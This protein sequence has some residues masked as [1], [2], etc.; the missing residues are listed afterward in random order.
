MAKPEG[1]AIKHADGTQTEYELIHVGMNDE[2][3]D[4]WRYPDDAVFGPGDQPYLAVLPAKTG[5]NI[6]WPKHLNG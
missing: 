4:I 6:P 5:I 2:G 3:I 1:A